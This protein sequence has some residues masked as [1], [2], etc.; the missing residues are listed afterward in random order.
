MLKRDLNLTHSDLPVL[1]K[2][3]VI[4]TSIHYSLELY[5]INTELTAKEMGL[6]SRAY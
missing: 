1:M 6:L 2:G 4:K 5:L 3:L